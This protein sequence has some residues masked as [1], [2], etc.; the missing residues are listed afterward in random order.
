MPRLVQLL[1]VLAALALASGAWGEAKP[2]AAAE[3]AARPGIG[4]ARTLESFAEAL[5][6]PRGGPDDAAV[7]ATANRAI[8]AAAHSGGLAVALPMG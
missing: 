3:T 4:Q 7:F 5:G 8:A 6:V 2:P 1:P